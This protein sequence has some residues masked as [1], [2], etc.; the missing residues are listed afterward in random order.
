MRVLSIRT[1]SETLVPAGL[2]LFMAFCLVA[3]MAAPTLAAQSIKIGMITGKT[4][5][6]GTSNKISFSGARFAVKTINDEGGI[7]GRPVEL[8]EYDNLSTAEGSAGAARQALA[9]GAVAVVGCNWSSHSLAMARVLQKA[10]VPMVSHSSTNPAVTQVGNYIFRACFTD[11]F[12]GQGL[13]HFAL[14]RLNSVT[15]VVLEDT[16]RTYS[17]GLAETFTKAFEAGG[18]RIVWKGEYTQDDYRVD[19]MLQ[20]VS[21]HAP[22]VLFVPGGYA[23]VAA[24]FGAAA[25]Y[26]IR[27]ARISGD[28][29]GI[30]LFEYIGDKAEDVYYSGHWSRWVNSKQS[31]DFVRRYEAEVGTVSQDTIA[32]AYDSVMLIKD[33]IERA[34]GTT[35]AAIRDG[36]ATTSGFMGVTGTIRFDDNGDPIKSLVINRLKFGGR[37]YLEQIDP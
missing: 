3:F 33:A 35:P 7:L 8:L 26:G 1:A 28:G 15:A 19:D 25:R 24:F 5:K 4:G 36:L 16:S 13:A 37:L 34:E 6:A 27:S 30:K 22:D 29:I 10:G 32:L 12:Q 31:K 14:T 21:E 11:S 20:A 9:D 18:G 17:T 23:D 2:M